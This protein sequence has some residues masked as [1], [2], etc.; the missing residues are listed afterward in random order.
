M[1]TALSLSLIGTCFV[2]QSRLAA[3]CQSVKVPSDHSRWSTR[4]SEKGNL[5]LVCPKH[6]VGQ[7]SRK[8]KHE[9]NACSNRSIRATC[10]SAMSSENRWSAGSSSSTLTSIESARIIPSTSTHS[11]ERKVKK[12]YFLLSPLL[13]CQWTND[14][15]LR[16]FIEFPLEEN[17]EWKR[18]QK[19]RNTP[20]PESFLRSAVHP[21]RCEWEQH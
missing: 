10:S 2:R 21:S 5:R 16:S 15:W 20:I 13:G 14:H 4:E 8:E 12:K 7:M 17:S 1:P 18:T 9:H 19:E 11:M 3:I 6:N